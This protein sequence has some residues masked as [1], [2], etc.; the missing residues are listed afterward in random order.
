M[1]HKL[2]SAMF[3]GVIG[4]ALTC[5]MAQAQSSDSDKDKQSADRSAK[6]VGQNMTVTGC[7]TKD[8]K[9]KNEYMI[10]GEDGK[11]WGLKST[12]VKLGDHLNHKVTVTGKVNKVEHEK[13]AGDLKVTS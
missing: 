9:E 13:E 5:G 3:A 10:T 7:L 6:T 12:A 11:T 1:L 4:I 2:S 8:E